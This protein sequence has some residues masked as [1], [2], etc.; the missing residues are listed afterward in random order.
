M[1]AKRRLRA[2]GRAPKETDR[3]V[4]RLAA[5]VAALESELQEL[6]P[7]PEAAEGHEA[8]LEAAGLITEHVPD[9]ARLLVVGSHGTSLFAIEHWP[10]ASF[11]VEAERGGD[12]GDG[13]D[14][15]AVARLEA[16]RVAEGAAFLVVPDAERAVLRR[17]TGLIEHLLDSYD[18]VADIEA[19]GML[20]DLRSRSAEPDR[21]TLRRELARLADGRQLAVLDWTETGLQEELADHHVFAPPSCDEVLPYLDDTVDVVLVDGR[22][23]L[24]EALRVAREGVVVVELPEEEGVARSL[25]VLSANGSAVSESPSIVVCA[26]APSEDPGWWAERLRE[27]VGDAAEVVAG[28]SLAVALSESG[29]EADVVVLLERGVVPLPGAVR[30]LARV[31]T[32]DGAAATGKL[33]GSD[34][35]LAAAG[36]SVFADGSVAAIGAGSTDV[37]APWHEFRRPVPAAAGSLAIGRAALEQAGHDFDSVLGLSAAAWRSGGRLVYQPDAALVQA[38]EGE[39]DLAPAEEAGSTW[40]Q[41]LGSR[42]ER[43]EPLDEEAWRAVVAQDDVEGA[44]A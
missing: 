13:H 31:V 10:I 37:S 8:V 22:E 28:A 14:L 44:P 1:S 15:A 25:E 12:P 43:P 20:F 16:E 9:D 19:V 18:V 24:E 17:H 23:G 36:R 27:A 41:L 33:L 35:A 5:R 40:A 32:E 11:P 38:L 4:A 21:P 29:A 6:R 42:P 2:L 30:S 7:R 3:A 34:G 39:H 26:Q